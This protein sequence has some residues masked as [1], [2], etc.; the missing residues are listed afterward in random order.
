MAAARFNTPDFEIFD[1][2]IVCLAGDG[3]MQEG[4]AMEAVEFAGHQQLDN[5]ILIYDSNDVTLDAMAKASQSED[6]AKRFEAIGFEVQTITGNDM[7]EFLDRLRARQE[8]RQRQAA[9]HHRQDAH[10]QGDSGSR[11]HPEG[12]RRRRREVRRRGAQGSRPARRALLRRARSVRLLR[13]TPEGAR[14]QVR[15]VDQEVRRLESRQPEAGRGIGRLARV[16]PR[17]CRRTP[18]TRRRASRKCSR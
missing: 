13:R 14:R 16:F 10:R 4:V 12:A 3:C 9:A 6:T 11:R 1:H 17:R 18:S 2:H 5:L 7:E 15:R 8:R